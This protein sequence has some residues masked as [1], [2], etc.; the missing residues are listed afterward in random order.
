M[1]LGC[2]RF[3]PAICRYFIMQDQTETAQQPQAS[4]NRSANRARLE[5][6]G[7]S[8]RSNQ[9]AARPAEGRIAVVGRNADAR[10]AAGARGGTPT[11]L[12]QEEVNALKQRG[13]LRFTGGDARVPQPVD[14]FER[15]SSSGLVKICMNFLVRDRFC[16]YGST[17]N[18][19]HIAGINDFTPA[20]RAKFQTFV[21]N[22]NMLAMATPGTNP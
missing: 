2:F 11:R 1:N 6:G 16:R 18:M 19:E 10:P 13:L 4:N 20:N 15:N 3:E 5:Q 9:P 8:N 12:S 17:C 21:Q 14:I 22:H 7:N